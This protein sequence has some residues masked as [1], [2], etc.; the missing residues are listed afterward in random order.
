MVHGHP[1]RRAAE[2]KDPAEIPKVSHR[3]GKPGLAIFD[4]C[5]AAST[6]LGMTEDVVICNSFA[7]NARSR[8]ATVRDAVSKAGR[9]LEIPTQIQLHSSRRPGE[10][11]HQAFDAP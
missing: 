9:R 11:R 2:S 10:L 7:P 1:E 6:S 4:G 8:N 5:V 3:D